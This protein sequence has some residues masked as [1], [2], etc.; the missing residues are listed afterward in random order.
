MEDA[1]YFEGGAAEWGNEADG[2][3]VSAEGAGRPGVGRE[4]AGREEPSAV[5]DGGRGGASE[6]REGQR[7][8]AGLVPVV[9]KRLFLGNGSCAE[10]LRVSKNGLPIEI[11]GVHQK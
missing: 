10:V 7:G 2:G 8:G 3:A 4:A 1:D 11:E 9:L 5:R 6:G